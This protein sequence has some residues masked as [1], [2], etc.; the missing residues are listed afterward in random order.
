MVDELSQGDVGR[1]QTNSELAS[2][3]AHKALVYTRGPVWWTASKLP[4][5]GDDVTAV[6]TV[7]EV[8]EDLTHNTVPQ[9]VKAGGTFGP[10]SLNPKNGRIDLSPIPAV[11]PVLEQGAQQIDAG[12]ARVAAIPTDGL[13]EEL[14]G[15]VR[16]LQ[17]KL[18][19]ASSAASS[20]ALAAELMPAMLGA[21]G[22]RTYLAVFQNNAEIR[23]QGGLTG[24][25][26][27]L[28]AND[29]KVRM[30]KQS[31][32]ADLGTFGPSFIDLTKEERS[33]FSTRLSI[34]PQDNTFVPDFPRSAE[35]LKQMWEAREP[36]KL[37]GVVSIDPVALGYLLGGTGPVKL[38]DGQTL[39][40]GNAAAVLMRDVYLNIADPEAQNNFFDDVARR[41]FGQV[42]GGAD[43]P[44][45]LLSGLTQAVGER[46]LM[47]WS[48]HSDEQQ[49]LS[50]TPIAGELSGH[51]E[52][53]PNVGV[54]INDS[55]ADKL[56][57]YLDYHVD[58][59]PR[60]CGI[61]G[62]QIIDVKLT[63]KSTVPE[64]TT[65]PRYLVGPPSNAVP[66][67]VMLNT[68]YLYAP[69]DGRVDEVTSDGRP[70]PS[71]E[72]TYDG[73]DVSSTTVSLK[74]GEKRVIDYVVITGRNQTGDPTLTTTPA[75]LGDGQGFVGPSAC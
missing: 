51:V 1:A 5:I 37:D 67:G 74:P 21:D 15:P 26:A 42:L 22:P 2:D 14:R 23:A 73:R 45:S 18:T 72:D 29:G 19:K 11:A 34:Y 63:M 16:E 55:A 39:D 56:S 59:S 27:L 36:E 17:D 70:L 38:R 46:R 58:V 33:L 12:R 25:Y 24:A 10:R 40:S 54:F 75:A 30:V 31:R 7:S 65:G 53:S 48:A 66:P 57:Y 49:K 68:F 44:K 41:V 8:V 69:V 50:G 6:R 52:K 61:D 64:G 47:M 3:S 71:A 62:N 13:V 4:W 60:S 35:I 20:A 9:L 32:P 43:N 28:R